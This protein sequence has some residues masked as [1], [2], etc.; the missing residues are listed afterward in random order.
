MP[1]HSKRSVTG[2]PFHEA[3][4]ETN[5]RDVR[6]V[7]SDLHVDRAAPGHSPFVIPT[8]GPNAKIPL[9]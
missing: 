8:G 9:S 4:I 6:L 1:S 3:K 7:F 5:G 2:I